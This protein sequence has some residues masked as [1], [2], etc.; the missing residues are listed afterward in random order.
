MILYSS[1]KN[2]YFWHFD[3]YSTTYS[4]FDTLWNKFSGTSNMG[5]TFLESFYPCQFLPKNNFAFAEKNLHVESFTNSK[6]L[7][8]FDLGVWRTLKQVYRSNKFIK[9]LKSF[10]TCVGFQKNL[11]FYLLIKFG[12]FKP[13]TTFNHSKVQF[14]YLTDVKASF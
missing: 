12:A 1:K 11:I 6:S 13:C 5:R 4:L 14:K 3:Q 8:R 10:K 2:W 7:R 9:F